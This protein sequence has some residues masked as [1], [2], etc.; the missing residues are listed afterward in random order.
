[1]VLIRRFI[2]GFPFLKKNQI[3]LEDLLIVDLSH[4]ARRRLEY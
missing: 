4:E 2:A 3:F 1:M